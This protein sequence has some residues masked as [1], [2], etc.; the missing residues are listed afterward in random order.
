MV[1]VTSRAAYFGSKQGVFRLDARSASGKRDDGDLRP[2]QDPAAARPHDLRARHR[3]TP[4]RAA[5]PPPIARACCGRRRR[6]TRADEVRGR[7]LRRPLLP[8]RVR[9][10]QRRRADAGRTRNPRV[11]LVASEHTGAAIARDLADRRARRAR[12]EDRRGARRRSALGTTAQV[13][14]AT[15]DA[16][17]WAPPRRRRE[18]RS[19]RRRAGRD[20]ARSRR[21]VRSGQGARGA[22]RS[23]S[24]PAARSRSELLAVLAD[25]RAPQQA[26]GHGRRPARRSARIRRACAVLTAQL[27]AH[28]DFLAKTEPDALGP[29]AKAIAGLGGAKLDPTAGR[30]RARR[31]ADSPRRADH[32][33]RRSRARDRRDGR[34]RRRRR[35]P[36]ARLALAALSRGRRARRRS[37]VGKAIV[38]ALETTA[39]PAS[40]SCCGRSRPIR[41]RNGTLP[42]GRRAVRTR[43]RL[44][45]LSD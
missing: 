40:A 43:A 11:E 26:Q 20:R 30:G 28:A 31:A 35:A 37:R 22:A 15:F 9:L 2:G 38:H 33:G 16:D 3:T 32:A 45:T 4:C 41:A 8:L 21:A 7:R 27:A 1:R 44:A 25:N 6:P 18:P 17:G 36:G 34:D 29:V 19:S 39:V 12:S 13:L 42:L 24:C 14:G 23:R 10:R 5:T